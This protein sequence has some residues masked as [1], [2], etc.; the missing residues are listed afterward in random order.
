M[1]RKIRVVVSGI[2]YP[3]TM[4]SYFIRALQ[5]RP[6]VELVLAGPFTGT[7]IPWNGGMELPWRYVV[8]PEIIL[9]SSLVSLGQC[10]SSIVESQLPWK[11]DLWIQVDAGFHFLNK[12]SAEVVAHVA[13]DPHVLRYDVQRTLCDVFFCMQAEYS[14]AG[15]V[16]LPYAYDPSCH[17]LEDIPKTHDACLIGLLYE[18]RANLVSSLRSAG[19][20]CHNSIGEIY[21]EYRTLYSQSRVAL[22][23]S[24][25]H[26]VNART[27]EAMGMSLPLVTNRIPDLEIHFEEGKHYLGFDTVSEAVSQ[28]RWVLDNPDKAQVIAQQ[29][30]ELVKHNHT[31]DARIDKIFVECGVK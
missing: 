4:M 26:D 13:T 8:T 9:P 21:D 16:F 1:K 12:P 19:M 20:S 30:H 28:V 6:D 11:P 15:D 3:F 14:K 18:T 17:Y 2:F 22:N 29:G 27:F 31:Y 25:L 7:S 10:H 24:S 5:R 23:W